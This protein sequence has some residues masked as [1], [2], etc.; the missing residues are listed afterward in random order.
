[1]DIGGWHGSYICD[2]DND[3]DED[4]FMTSHGIA[5]QNDTGL[6]VLFRNNGNGTFTEIAQ[7][8]GLDGGLHGR[9]SRELHGASWLDYDNDGDFDL[10]MPN[11][12]TFVDDS[13]YHAYDELYRNNGDGTFTNVSS[14]AGLPKDDFCRRG[15]CAGDF[16]KDGH[17][18]IFVVN[19]IYATYDTVVV[20]SP[21]KAIYMNQGNG[22]FSLEHRGIEF[23]HWSE[24]TTTLD[25]NND[26]NVDILEAGY[27]PE[28][29]IHLWANDGTGHFSDVGSAVGLPD[30]MALEGSVTT[31]DIDHDGD[32]DIYLEQGLY[33]N[34]KGRFIFTSKI[35]GAEHMVLADIDN[36][37][38]L[39][40][41]SGGI[42]LN[43]GDGTFTQ[44]QSTRL[45]VICEGRGCMAFDA[46]NDGDLDLIFNRSDR[47]QPYLRFYRNELN[48]DRWLKVKLIGP[49]GQV[50]APGAKLWLFEAGHLGQMDHL[51]GYR[52][53]VTA[54]GF[55]CGP[56][57]IQHFGLG[58]H[59]S[60]DLKVQ[61]VTGEI[62]KKTGVRRATTV[63]IDATQLFYHITGKI[64]YFMDHVPIPDVKVEV[65]DG[66][67]LWVSS[68]DSGHYQITN[69][70]GSQNYVV[71]P[72]KPPDSDVGEFILSSYDATL[73]AQAAMGLR[74]ITDYQTI[75]ADVDRDGK[76]CLYDAALIVR[77]VVGLPKLPS[78]HVGEWAFV[79]D[80]L[81][82]Q[83]LLSDQF[84]QDYVGII[85][86]NVHG[87]WL[88]PDRFNKEH[89]TTHWE[90]KV[91]VISVPEEDLI[92]VPLLS[93]T[94]AEVLSADM[95]LTYNPSQ[96][97]FYK[98]TKTTLSREF[99]LVFNE[100]KEKGRLRIGMYGI[101]PVTE[102]GKLLDIAFKIVGKVA[103][104]DTVLR[105]RYR[106]NDGAMTTVAAPIL[107]NNQTPAP[108]NFH[109]EQNYPNPF[110]P[111]TLIEY[112]VAEEREVVIKIYNF[113]GQE[114]RTLVDR[115][116]RPG[117]YQVI[118]DGTSNQGQ[119]VSA[120]I[121]FCQMIAGN[122]IQVRKMVVV[123]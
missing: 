79:P 112:Q 82:Y 66:S 67:S 94:N 23:L 123:R 45:G 110:N 100:E 120:G 84:D 101:K 38:D 63:V 74:Q 40:I 11:T 114:V 35:G 16:N 78:S 75:A 76:L 105:E 20:P 88:P 106:L 72:S 41:I 117:F 17:L 14:I 58:P 56:S 68:D 57:P 108:A 55:V 47:Y 80:R 115:K 81:R 24:G 29:G 122:W 118:W 18:D 111:A 87:G 43:N 90:E 32:M 39:D 46:D 25:Y 93:E 103:E 8:L 73:T 98:I 34:D 30:S 51:I 27:A 85:L 28:A 22:T 5:Y 1:Q 42:F 12:D 62:A 31:G 49:N 104:G 92:T 15:A 9:Y 89:G 69:L 4:L 77:H 60:V 97:E 3:G 70:K 121:Y 53:V 19:M 91:V 44:D 13:T 86:G 116:L 52:E 102:A 65:A 83:P 119:S 71:T 113:L 7:L 2:Y 6:N 109:L 64:T 61:F 96:L 99:E 26:G 36:D 54:T 50:G 48:N 107:A 95:E 10:F 21:Y 59:D 37:T 33:R